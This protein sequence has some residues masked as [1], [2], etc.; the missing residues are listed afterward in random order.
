MKPGTKIRI[1]EGSGIDSGKTGVVVHRGCI[2]FKQ[3]AG[4]LI[5]D[6]PGHYKP[7]GSDELPVRLDSGEIITMFKE[8]LLPAG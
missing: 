1:A 5:P 2:K 8:R 7:L 6:L 4:G 3:T